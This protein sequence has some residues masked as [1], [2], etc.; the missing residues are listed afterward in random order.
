MK[1]RIVVLIGIVLCV[2]LGCIAF[3][4]CNNKKKTDEVEIKPEKTIEINTASDLLQAAK[5]VGVEYSKYTL[6][7]MSDINL[8]NEEWKPIGMTLSKAFCGTFDGN[9]KTISGLKIT[10]WESNGTPKYVAKEIIG[11][12]EDGTPVY[13][14][15]E[16]VDLK[17]GEEI[18]ASDNETKLTAVTQIVREGDNEDGNYQLLSDGKGTFETEAGYGSV[19][20]FG[21]TKGATIK[22]LTVTGADISFF[23][24]GNYSYAGIISGYDVASK[25]ENV[26]VSNGKI[27]VATTY[28]DRINYSDQHGTAVSREA[29]GVSN[30]Y[31]GGVIGYTKG[32]TVYD[33]ETKQYVQNKTELKTVNSNNFKFDNANYAACF[34]NDFE[35]LGTDKDS[36]IYLAKTDK[37]GEY[38]ITVINE[39]SDGI[40][41]VYPVQTYAGGAI[42]YASEASFDGVNVDGFNKATEI[43]GTKALNN[44]TTVMAR[45]AYFGGIA[46]GLYNSVAKNA[47]S[48]N[49]FVNSI[50]WSSWMNEDISF[51]ILLFKNKATIGGAYGIVAH[52]E[53]KQGKAEKAYMEV[54]GRDLQ[55]VCLGG[56]AGYVDDYSVIDGVAADTV[57]MYSTYSGKTGTSTQSDLGSVMGGAVGVLRNSTFKNATVDNIAMEITDKNEQ[58]YVFVKS[59]VSQLYGNSV[60]SES[61]AKNIEEY[62]ARNTAY[63]A[64]GERLSKMLKPSLSKNTIVNED[65]YNSIRLYYSPD[66]TQYSNVYVTV[67]AET[68]P[69]D[70][71]DNILIP[72]TIYKKVDL[73]EEYNK[74]EPIAWNRYYLYLEEEDNYVSIWEKTLDEYKKFN[75]EA[76][77][78]EKLGVYEVE[79]TAANK[80][81]A[82]AADTYYEY[83]QS[84]AKFELTTDQTAV[85]GKTY[86]ILKNDEYIKSYY[87]D[88]KV[89]A[90]SGKELVVDQKDPENA[91]DDV[92]AYARYTLT[93][94]QV[95][96][97]VKTADGYA[98]AESEIYL[99]TFFAK[100]IGF[101]PDMNGTQIKYYDQKVENRNFGKYIFVNG[102]P[103][104]VEATVSYR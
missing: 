46:G 50:D 58:S 77:Y 3:A 29:V 55:N 80:H 99:D 16:I 71:H 91:D 67:F 5:Y 15:N 101:K 44:V 22:D 34:T 11:W 4:G 7:L 81:M 25:L 21:Y 92:T 82:L 86:Y 85:D 9:G 2:V 53:V 13:K 100:D 14:S 62:S 63:A 24:S 94:A 84:K 33:I 42:G 69:I 30:Q 1:R 66:G 60:F 6:K 43:D 28:E 72:T 98:L 37:K 27:S 70:T 23:T 73:S 61:T 47:Y 54:G 76:L 51:S 96:G 103:V 39:M 64:T 12:L 56:F 40:D 10:G 38:R 49:I 41:Y 48:A 52:S 102:R 26:T 93:K 18:L 68:L 45:S 89:Y 87:L 74:D 95:D 78:A 35:F 88:V 59:I 8:A 79:L 36:K 65:G 75:P 32:N 57:Y 97:S 19:G 90:E 83:D 31:V 104:F 20:L 17:F